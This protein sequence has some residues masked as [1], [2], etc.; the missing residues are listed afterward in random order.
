MPVQLALH[1]FWRFEIISYTF[2]EN[3]LF[4]ESVPVLIFVALR[5]YDSHSVCARTTSFEME[6]ILLFS[7]KFKD[8]LI[9]LHV[10]RAC[11][12]LAKFPKANCLKSLSCF[13]I[14]Y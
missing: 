9:G 12:L 5:W 11:V 14:S 2:M 7:F 3:I 10:R 1:R 8:M 4:I 6:Q 13:V